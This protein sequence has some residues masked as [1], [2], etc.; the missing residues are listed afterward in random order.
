[1]SQQLKQTSII[2][3]KVQDNIAGTN[4][5]ANATNSLS[6][7]N[8]IK[9]LQVFSRPLLGLCPSSEIIQGNFNHCTEKPRSIKQAPF[10]LH[11]SLLIIEHVSVHQ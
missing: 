8:T 1:M 3:S 6:L 10:S 9:K 2:A 5:A 4:V 11:H 7:Q